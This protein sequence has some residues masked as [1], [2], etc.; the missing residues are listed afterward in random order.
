M[1]VCWGVLRG[2]LYVYILSDSVVY[3]YIT[4]WSVCL[5]NY[6]LQRVRFMPALK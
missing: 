3:H 4:V 2:E 5:D 6:K 1:C